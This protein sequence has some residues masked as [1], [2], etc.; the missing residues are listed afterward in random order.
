MASRRARRAAISAGPVAEAA[1]SF[2]IAISD[3]TSALSVGVVKQRWREL[4]LQ[5]HPDV[6]GPGGVESFLGL[7]RDYQVLLHAC[8]DR[9]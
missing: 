6:V 5:R 7:K 1:R 2:G 9:A 4:A 8:R 3:D